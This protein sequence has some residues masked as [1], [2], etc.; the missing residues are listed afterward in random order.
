MEESTRGPKRIVGPNDHARIF[1]WSGTFSSQ[2]GVWTNLTLHLSVK[3]RV[4]L[5]LDAFPFVVIRG[6]HRD[7]PH[8]SRLLQ[9]F[10]FSCNNENE[11]G[12]ATD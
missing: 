10:R 9:L 4:H 11:R 2:Y 6:V 7:Q 12:S 5:W 8:R 1:P 3:I